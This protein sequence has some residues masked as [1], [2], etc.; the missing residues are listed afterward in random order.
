MKADTAKPNPPIAVADLTSDDGYKRLAFFL[1]TGPGPG[2]A[3][4]LLPYLGSAGA[5]SLALACGFLIERYIGLQ[6]V[7]L[8]FLMAILA[9]AIAWG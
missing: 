8:V 5:V 4:R 9:S 1:G 2:N 7:L 6:S 3:F